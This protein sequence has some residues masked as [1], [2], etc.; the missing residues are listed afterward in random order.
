MSEQTSKS[1]IRNN[2]V[3]DAITAIAVD[4]SSCEYELPI[5]FNNFLYNYSNA[6]I[7]VSGSGTIGDA[8]NPGRNTLISNNYNNGAVD[9]ENTDMLN[10]NYRKLWY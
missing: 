10:Y 7:S 1:S 9:V 5:V 4:G 3:F 2:C 8:T 6:G